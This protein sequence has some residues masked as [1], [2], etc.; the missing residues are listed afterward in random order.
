ML[1]T[2]RLQAHTQTRRLRSSGFVP[3]FF[4][5]FHSVKHGIKGI[6]YTLAVA[7]LPQADSCPG[8][9]LLQRMA[10]N[11]ADGH[12]HIVGIKEKQSSPVSYLHMA[13]T[14]TKQT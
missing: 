3:Q 7:Y 14:N 1:D 4:G 6:A 9:L 8:K 2:Y 5:Q 11:R 12:H 13:R 10:G